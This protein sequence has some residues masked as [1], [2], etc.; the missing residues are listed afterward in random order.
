MKSANF[1]DYLN[2]NC[3]DSDP[4]LMPVSVYEK[5]PVVRKNPHTKSAKQIHKHARMDAI[6]GG[7][8]A[9]SYRQIS[10]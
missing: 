10:Q 3:S 8:H 7:I 1:S 9:I 2:S 5:S 6:K 4:S